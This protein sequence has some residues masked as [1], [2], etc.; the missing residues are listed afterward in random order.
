MYGIGLISGGFLLDEGE[1]GDAVERIRLH[2]EPGI[3]DLLT[4]VGTD[5]V[6]MCMEGRER[7]FDPAKLFDGEQLYGQSDIE[8]MLS[9]GLVNRVGEEFWFYGDQ[10]GH[11]G[12]V[13]EHRSQSIEFV[14]KI[15][16]IHALPHV[17]VRAFRWNNS[18]DMVR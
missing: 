5:S 7:L 13:C 6:R 14:L 18:R 4:A 3:G 10:M 15:R 2:L 11:H 17:D 16:V 1:T 8:F 9:G 12:F